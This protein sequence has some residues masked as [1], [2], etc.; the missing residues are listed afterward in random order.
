MFDYLVIAHNGKCA[1]R[2]MSQAGVPRIHDLLRVRFTPKLDTKNQTMQLCSI[3]AL[4]IKIKTRLGL[5]FVGLH[6]EKDR[7]VNEGKGRDLR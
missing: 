4:M 6:V 3:W 1:D 7:E 5:P 2:L